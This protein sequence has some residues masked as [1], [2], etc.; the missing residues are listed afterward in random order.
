M[1]PTL[2]T[3]H[4]LRTVRSFTDRP[5]QQEDLD[6]II[7]ASVRAA[8]SSSRQ[9]YSIIVLKDEE[10]IHAICGYKGT[11]ALVYCV[12]YNRLK[13]IAQY[14]HQDF[15]VDP[16]VD[17][18]TGSIDTILAVQ[19]AAIAAKSLGIGSW[20]TNG[21][22]RN[23]LHNTYELL[24]LPS[25]YCFPLIVL[26]LGYPDSDEV[27]HH[28]RLQGP[29]VVHYDTYHP[30]DANE[31]EADIKKH[32]SPEKEYGVYSQW[33][34]MGYPHYYHWFFQEWNTMSD[35]DIFTPFLK[36]IGFIK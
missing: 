26:I 17:F 18:M 16:F 32:D 20:F 23:D 25:K 11:A 22:H 34:S 15:E 3:I 1:N 14:L 7:N 19:T 4:Q 29:G 36:E 13:D 33:E 30:M 9:C 8:N 2:E 35:K 12:D 24:E 31:I 28:G 10:K 5:I 27:H 6:T 21:V